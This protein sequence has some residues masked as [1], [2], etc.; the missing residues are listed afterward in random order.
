[1]LDQNIQKASTAQLTVVTYPPQKNVL[2]L[3][4]L[5]TLS[6]VVSTRTS[7]VE[8]IDTV[9][10]VF[11]CHKLYVSTVVVFYAQY[12]ITAK[13]T[14]N[15]ALVAMNTMNGTLGTPILYSPKVPAVAPKNERI[16][17]SG[18]GHAVFLHTTVNRVVFGSESCSCFGSNISHGLLGNWTASS[19]LDKK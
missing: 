7:Y 12:T 4:W 15:S 1:M 14:K 9:A 10:T 11:C 13:L 8:T 6:R 5:S 2:G 16:F 17:Q 18:V 3:H 19:D